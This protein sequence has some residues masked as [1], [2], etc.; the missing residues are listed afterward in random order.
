MGNDGSGKTTVAK[1]L[2]KIF[3]DLGYEVIYKHEYEYAVLKFLFKVVGMEKIDQERK[4]MLVK[5]EKSWK[6]YL[7]PVLVWF[8]IH[9]SLLY[10]KLFKRR[11]IVILDRYLYD[12]YLSFKYL[13]YLTRF[14]EGLFIKC[15]L[16]PEIGFILWVEPQIAY[17]RKKS[18]HNYHMSFY[19]K[20]TEKYIE[21]SKSIGIKAVNTNKTIVETINEILRMVPR[22]KLFLFLIKG[23]QNRV[24]FSV[25]EK[26]KLYSVYPYVAQIFE[27][28]RR[29]MEHTLAFVKDILGKNGVHHCI[30]KTLHTEGWIGNDVDILVSKSDFNRI[31]ARLKESNVFHISKF[32][33]KGKADINIS[34]GLA[35][36][37]HS[38]VGWRNVSFISAEDIILNKNFMFKKENGL[39]FANEK[40]NSI[41]IIIHTFEKGFISL[42]EYNFLRSFFDE[43]FMQSNFSHLYTLLYDYILW[44][45]KT[46]TEKQNNSYPVFIPISIIIKCYLKLLHSWN[47]QDNIFWKLKGFIRDISL[48]IFWKVRYKVKNKLP[49]EIIE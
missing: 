2:A 42:D 30:I 15:S 13:G 27:E 20:Q 5:R 7:W 37:L 3:R 43:A 31:I 28:R 34:N 10:F 1:E 41:I 40:I 47:M 26:Y 38:Y 48:M 16:K 29:K 23:M 44:I 25:I 19:A 4:K 32:M 17:L 45:K 9:C 39:Y 49:F 33:E 46:L 12:H 18:T 35:I 24:L 21:L 6:Y 36:D 22:D 11:T 8:D 14:S